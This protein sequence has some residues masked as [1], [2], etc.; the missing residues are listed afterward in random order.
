MDILNTITVGDARELTKNIPDEGIDLI[1]TD[2]PY[3][4]VYLPLYGWLAEEAA[5]ILKPGGFLLTYAGSLWKDQVMLQLGQHL[6]FFWDYIIVYLDHSTLMHP[7]KTMNTC[8]SILAYVKGQGKPNDWVRGH[9]VSSGADKRFHEWGQNG[10]V[11]AYYLERFS[12][13]GDTVFEPFTGGGTT[14]Y[15][16]K[17]LR[18]N[19]IAFEIAPATADIARKR[20]E[21]TQL[22]LMPEVLEQLRL[23]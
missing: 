16:C 12:R 13:P 11:V 21:T 20:L 19:F 9:I 6:S 23:A 7:T 22:L 8:R 10:K 18:R 2:P 4:K 15:I 5:R 17:Q 14:C 3:P 1:F